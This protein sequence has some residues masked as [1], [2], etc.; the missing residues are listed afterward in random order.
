MRPTQLRIWERGREDTENTVYYKHNGTQWQ[1]RRK[2]AQPS[3]ISKS[4]GK[5]WSILIKMVIFFRSFQ[6]DTSFAHKDMW[7]W[8][9]YRYCNKKTLEIFLWKDCIGHQI[10][11][12]LQ[13]SGARY[14]GG[15]V[16]CYFLTWNGVL[17]VIPEMQRSHRDQ[18]DS[19]KKIALTNSDNWLGK[20]L[21][22]TF[23]S[24]GPGQKPLLFVSIWLRNHYPALL[25]LMTK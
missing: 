16:E 19:E 2:L 8:E 1:R 3:K 14:T 17:K 9:L 21:E 18:E 24:V 25:L 4:K 22:N 23:L 13:D 20:S 12:R 11:D 7:T 6:R 5:H 15:L 10:A